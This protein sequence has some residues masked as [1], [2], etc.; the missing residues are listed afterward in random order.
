MAA[1]ATSRDAADPAVRRSPA[2]DARPSRRRWRREVDD[3]LRM[4]RRHGARVVL[5]GNKICFSWP[6]GHQLQHGDD[7]QVTAS[8]TPASG[9]RRDEKQ[10]GRVQRRA[11]GYYK[12]GMEERAR[13]QQLDLEAQLAG[14]RAQQQRAAAM[15]SSHAAELAQAAEEKEAQPLVEAAAAVEVA[16]AEAAAADEVQKR[17][18]EVEAEAAA[19]AA[20][21][22]QRPEEVGMEEEVAASGQLRVEERR[23]VRVDASD[24]SGGTVTKKRVVAVAVEEAAA[25]AATAAAAMATA[26][27]AAART[28]VERARAEEARATTMAEA[29]LTRAGAA[30]GAWVKVVTGG[31][32]AG[33]KGGPRGLDKPTGIRRLSTRAAGGR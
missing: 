31:K 13:K 21:Q 6:R 18:R 2:D 7:N 23:C 19:A 15:S 24:E 12:R 32:A 4:A 20:Q 10:N 30:S 33:G 5:D 8:S 22:Q 28:A 29:A 27:E 26:T 16:A 9:E 3:A 25:A 14:Q 11:P 17:P 1:D